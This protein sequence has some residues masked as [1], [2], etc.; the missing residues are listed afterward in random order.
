MSPKTLLQQGRSFVRRYVYEAKLHAARRKQEKRRPCV[1]MMPS[2]QPWSSSS[3]LRTWLVAPEL[4][5]LGWRV[6]VMPEPLDLKQRH[7]VLEL[8]RPD[9]IFLQQTRHPLNQ[10]SLYP[11]YRCVLDAD[12]ADYLDPRYQDT[13]RECARDAYR[14][15]GG[16]RY[17]AKLLGQFNPRKPDV[18]WTCTPRPSSPPKVAP[19]NRPPVVAWAHEAP[20]RFPVEAALIQKVMIEVSKRTKCIFWLFGTDPARATEWFEPI[21]AAGGEC[22]AIPML[23][24]SD[25]L[26]KV[27]EAAVGLQPVCLDNE[28]SRGRSFGKIL[29]YLGGQVAIVASNVVDHPLFFRSGENGMLV[30]DNV[31][32]WA[33]AIVTL[34]ENRELRVSMARA[35]WQDFHS[36]LTTEVF[37]KLLDPVLRSS[38][39]R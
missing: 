38:I 36:R 7:R 9:V 28:F 16:S 21:K 8:E 37:A 26:D 23:S 15:I 13:I 31:D 6:V 29:A 10:P 5:R 34:L 27:A 25:Y 18:I 30:S 17:V 24:Y 33:N 20:L 39:E 11:S 3:N 32:E 2:N 35:G 14:I 12:D 4:E 19:E 1:V 22:V